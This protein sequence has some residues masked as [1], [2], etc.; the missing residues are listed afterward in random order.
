MRTTPTIKTEISLL[1]HR[2][3]SMETQLE[4]MKVDLKSVSHNTEKLIDSII[5][6]SLTQS[7]GLVTKYKEI[8]AKVNEHEELVK[9]LKWFWLGVFTLGSLMAIIIEIVLKTLFGL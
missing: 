6:N 7:D 9:K 1:D 3:S 8:K 4:D 2:L 5:G